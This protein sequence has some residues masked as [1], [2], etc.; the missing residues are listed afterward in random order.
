MNGK[1]LADKRCFVFH[2]H[3]QEVVKAD[4]YKFEYGAESICFSFQNSVEVSEK[5]DWYPTK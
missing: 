2:T 4:V 5:V 1:F 3:N